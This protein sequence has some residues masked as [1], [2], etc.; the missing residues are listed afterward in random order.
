M[1]LRLYLIYRKYVSLAAASVEF[2]GIIMESIREQEGEIVMDPLVLAG[3]SMDHLSQV[4][5][6]VKWIRQ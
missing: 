5:G 6:M 3:I 1:A 4:S 2:A